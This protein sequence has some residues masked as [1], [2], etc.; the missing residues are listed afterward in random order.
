MSVTNYY[1]YYRVDP[2]KLVELRRAV[3]ALFEVM[4][5]EFAVQGRWMRR[6]DDPTTYMEA[7]EGVS[8]AAKF[9][10]RLPEEAERLGFARW[11]E[12]GSARHTESFV[13]AEG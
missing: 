2:A 8:D 11:L 12:R 3:M 9:E 4:A 1:V 10:S 5:R 13:A 7:Y 6:R